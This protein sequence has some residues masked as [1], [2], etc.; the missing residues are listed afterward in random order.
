LLEHVVAEVHGKI[1]V[2]E[3]VLCDAYAMGEAER[4]VLRDKS[5]ADAP[6]RSISNCFTNFGPGFT[7]NDANLGDTRLGKSFDAIEKNGLVG[8]GN[9]LF[10]A[11]VGDGAK[12]GAC[13]AAEDKSFHVNEDTG[14]SRSM[15]VRS[16]NGKKYK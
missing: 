5:D 8:D 13:T 7:D 3:K 1:V 2:V 15:E 12:P 10:G 14:H 11:G 9:Q 4:L 16:W 6:P